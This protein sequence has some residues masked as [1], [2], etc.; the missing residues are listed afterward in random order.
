[1]GDLVALVAEKMGRAGGDLDHVAGPDPQ[2]IANP[3]DNL[4]F[5]VDPRHP[6]DLMGVDVFGRGPTGRQKPVQA[7]CILHCLLKCKPFA[8][9]GVLDVCGGHA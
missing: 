9:Y 3:D 8:R 6:L 4:E 7:N 5:A 2:N 1:V